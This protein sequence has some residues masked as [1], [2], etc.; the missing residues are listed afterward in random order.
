MRIS[1]LVFVFFLSTALSAH[2]LIVEAE[3]RSPFARVQVSYY[4]GAEARDA[5]VTV[6]APDSG[7]DS[8]VSGRTDRNGAF[9]FVPDQTGQWRIVADDGRGHREVLDLSVSESAA[10]PAPANSAN[11]TPPANPARRSLFERAL[12]G[13]SVLFGLTGLWM[14]RRSRGPADGNASS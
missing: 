1:L 6:W 7:E 13:L 14:W 2:E 5:D 4:D 10:A 12:T 11:P 3:F 9:A 8:F